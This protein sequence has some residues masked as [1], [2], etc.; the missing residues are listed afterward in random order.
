M[1]L[2][3]DGESNLDRP[4]TRA[5]LKEISD[6]V[7]NNQ[8]DLGTPFYLYVS[9]PRTLTLL[10]DVVVVV[11]DQVEETFALKP[12]KLSARRW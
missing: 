12:Q 6:K 7:K 2:K 10:A 11:A 4:L 5:E 1:S 8:L 9:S 3:Q